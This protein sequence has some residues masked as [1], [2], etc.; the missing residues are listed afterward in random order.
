MP[1]L[2]SLRRELQEQV[3]SV[4]SVDRRSENVVVAL[5]VLKFRGE[6]AAEGCAKVQTFFSIGE[7]LFEPMRL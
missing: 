7:Q 5:D 2:F 4:L 6:V 1:A 3:F